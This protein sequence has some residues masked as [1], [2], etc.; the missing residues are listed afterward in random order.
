MLKHLVGIL[1]LVS[2]LGCATWASAA[3]V[4]GVTL[5]QVQTWVSSHNN[6]VVPV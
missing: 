4:K 5:A 3:V 6:L 1:C 2:V